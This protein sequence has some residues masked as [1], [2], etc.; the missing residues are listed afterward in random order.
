M[1]KGKSVPWHARA[2]GS[3]SG[4][5]WE[6]RRKWVGCQKTRRMEMQRDNLINLLPF[7]VLLL[8]KCHQSGNSIRSSDAQWVKAEEADPASKE[9]TSQYTEKHLVAD[10]LPAWLAANEKQAEWLTSNGKKAGRLHQ[11]LLGRQQRCIS[12]ICK[13][14][15]ESQWK[16]AG[17]VMHQGHNFPLALYHISSLYRISSRQVSRRSPQL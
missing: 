1:P 9:N 8:R 2:G 17:F 12:S 5:N 10:S 14:T 6:E 3:S 16:W 7:Q 4:G 15:A 13:K 11:Q